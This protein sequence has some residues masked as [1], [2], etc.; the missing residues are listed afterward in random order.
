MRSQ[1]VTHTYYIPHAQDVP[2][3]IILSYMLIYPDS[4]HIT[5]VLVYLINIAHSTALLYRT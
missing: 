5:N 1:Y 2:I 3:T 4:T